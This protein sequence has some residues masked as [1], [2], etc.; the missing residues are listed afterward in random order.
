MDFVTQ[1]DWATELRNLFHD[2]LDGTGQASSDCDNPDTEAGLAYAKIKAVYPHQ[3]K[4]LL[5][6]SNP[7]QMAQERA[8]LDTVG[9]VKNLTAADGSTLF[10]ELQRYVDSK[11]KGTEQESEMEY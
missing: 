10:R 5:C 3:T 1:E 6:G 7:D 2:I 8:V 9:S 11:E 4:A